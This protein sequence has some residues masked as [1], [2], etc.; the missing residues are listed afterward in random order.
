[1]QQNITARQRLDPQV[2]KAV[3][4]YRDMGMRMNRFIQKKQV[5]ITKLNENMLVKQELDLLEDETPVFKL[6]G[7][8]LVRN[9]LAEA[10]ANVKQRIGYIETDIKNM[11]MKL[12]TMKKRYAEAGEKLVEM[13][14][15][16]AE[17]ET[18]DKTSS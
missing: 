15:K 13:Q 10:K 17:K 3:D 11:D 8:V 7:S 1:M 4:E 18:E 9:D 12:S 16:V 14:K 6:I 5:S 2:A